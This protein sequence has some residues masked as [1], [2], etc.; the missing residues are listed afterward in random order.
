M[1]DVAEFTNEVKR[2]SETLAI[3][4]QIEVKLEHATVVALTSHNPDSHFQGSIYDLRMPEGWQL[5]DYGRLQKDGEIK[6]IGRAH[7]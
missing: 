6:K 3:I 4:R 7:V 5:S 2:D 1:A